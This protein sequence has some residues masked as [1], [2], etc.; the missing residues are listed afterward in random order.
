MCSKLRDKRGVKLPYLKVEGWKRGKQLKTNHACLF[1]K[2]IIITLAID[3]MI[4]VFNALKY[5]IS[6][7][8]LTVHI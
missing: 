6:K 7:T 2:S 3:N 1:I 8:L 5:C 4:H